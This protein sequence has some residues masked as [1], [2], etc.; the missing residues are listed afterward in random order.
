MP[1]DNWNYTVYGAILNSNHSLGELKPAP[2]ADTGIAVRWSREP[3]PAPSGPW[4]REWEH[5]G[6]IW[7]RFARS[8]DGYFLEFPGRAAFRVASDGR[9]VDCFPEPQV[10]EFSVR[11]L[12][13]DQVLPLVM[14][15][16]GVP[17]FHGSAVDLGFGAVAFVGQSGRGKSTLACFFARQGNPSGVS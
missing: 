3:R 13:L 7:L 5:N 8:P 2:A 9:W 17:V 4:F 10:P 14:S 12:L 1:T 15:R 11:T 16:Q 6:S